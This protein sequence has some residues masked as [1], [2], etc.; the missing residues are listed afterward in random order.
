MPKKQKSGATPHEEIV[1]EELVETLPGSTRIKIAVGAAL[2]VASLAGVAWYA[3]SHDGPIIV[4]GTAADLGMPSVHTAPAP[5][6]VGVP[7]IL[8]EVVPEAS[9]AVVEEPVGDTAL[10]IE[11]ADT[12]L[13]SYNRAL[14]NAIG[15]RNHDCMIY[16]PKASI[17]LEARAAVE[18]CGWTLLTEISACF[19]SNKLFPNGMQQIDCDAL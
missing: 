14:D 19:Y 12:I 8:T 3:S 2:L 1:N 17:E 16:A 10:A 6:A 11:S 13:V 9:P 7:D 18:D 4:R 15:V 5:T